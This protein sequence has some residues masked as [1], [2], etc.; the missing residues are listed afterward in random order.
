[1]SLAYETKLHKH[2]FCA[3]GKQ[4]SWFYCGCLVRINTA[5]TTKLRERKNKKIVK[6][7][8]ELI[9]LTFVKR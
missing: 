2:L 7:M 9:L 8:E 1:M 4:A 3:L 5:V 6:F